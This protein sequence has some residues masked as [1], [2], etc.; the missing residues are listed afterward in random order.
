MT[1]EELKEL[2][3]KVEALRIEGIEDGDKLISSQCY[4]LGDEVQVL[5]EVYERKI[6]ENS[7]KYFIYKNKMIKPINV[8]NTYS[9][10][11][12]FLWNFV[13][14]SGYSLDL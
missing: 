12:E 5:F 4:F 1:D 3:R 14:E 10:V 11:Q 2:L 13:T 6:G 8:V 7:T 9:E